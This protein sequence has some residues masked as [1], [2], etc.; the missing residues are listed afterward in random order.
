MAVQARQHPVEL[1][2]LRQFAARLTTPTALFDRD[3]LLIYLNPAAEHMF[4]IDF[5][6]IGELSLQQ[7]LAIAQP[8]DVHGAPLTPDTLPVGKTLGEGTPELR[9]VAIRDLDGQLHRLGTTTIP[10][11]GLG[12]SLYGAMSLFWKLEDDAP[13]AST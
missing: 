5:A 8:T 7:V 3:G 11:H 10:V 9:T 1:I 13:A 2:L 12:G 6:S 4:G